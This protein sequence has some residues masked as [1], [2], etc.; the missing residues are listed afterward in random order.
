[1]KRLPVGEQSFEKLILNKSVYVDKTAFIQQ[2]ISTGG[3]YYFLSRPRRFGKS[4]FL[5]TIQAFFEGKKELFEG[6]YIYDK[7]DWDP[8]PVILLDMSGLDASSVDTLKSTLVNRLRFVARMAGI[9]VSTDNPNSLLEGIIT[10][11]YMLT[12]KRVVLLVD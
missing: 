12:N 6:L 7:T 9:E 8:H 3:G 4:L 1:M 10:S 5:S 2:L 11:L